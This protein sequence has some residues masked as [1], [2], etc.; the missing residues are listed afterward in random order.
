MA[1]PGDAA[2]LAG[3][4]AVM[5][6][7]A[8]PA[9]AGVSV[10]RPTSGSG[11]AGSFCVL[12]SQLPPATDATHARLNFG[13][14]QANPVSEGEGDQNPKAQAG[15]AGTGDRG[16]V[17][18]GCVRHTGQSRGPFTSL[19]ALGPTRRSPDPGSPPLPEKSNSPLNLFFC[20]D[21]TL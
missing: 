21:V 1:G 16:W 8:D 9:S 20:R 12:C 3:V 15:G 10:L 18:C 19:S 13:V 5:V 6:G 7:V 14:T 17:R 4:L 11:S 2:A